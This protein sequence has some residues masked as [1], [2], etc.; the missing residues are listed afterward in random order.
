[1]TTCTCIY[2]HTLTTLSN[3]TT[4]YT[5]GTCPVCTDHVH[6]QFVCLWYY[7]CGTVNLMGPLSIIRLFGYSAAKAATHLQE[8][9]HIRQD[10]NSTCT[11]YVHHSWVQLVQGISL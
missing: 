7:M 9:E 2:I 6:T 11:N 10:I 5:R 8:L 4:H 1:M 3:T